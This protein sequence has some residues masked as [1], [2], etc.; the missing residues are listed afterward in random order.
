VAELKRREAA[1]LIRQQQQGLGNP[2]MS[3][4]MNDH[5][6]VAAGNTLYWSGKWKT[7]RRFLAG[8]MKHVLGGEWG[9]AEIAKPLSD[10][11]P[12]M[13]WYEE[14]CHFKRRHGIDREGNPR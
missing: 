12:I 8:Y 14:Y 1:E 5:Q 6:I 11:H 7:F 2:I 13:Q 4:K 10:R 9:N 3:F